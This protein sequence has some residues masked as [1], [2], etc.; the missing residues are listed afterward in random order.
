M[1]GLIYVVGIGPGDFDY[2]CNKAISALGNSDIIVGYKTYIELVKPHFENK[3]FLSSA[4]KKEVDRCLEVLKLAEQGKTVSLISSGDP[5]IYGMAGIMIEIVAAHNSD[6]QVEV[7]PGISASASAASL[8]G[9]PLMNDFAVISLSNLLTPWET[10]EKRLHALAQ[11]DFVISVYN[12]KSKT[13][14]DP[15]YNAIEI[16]LKYK[17]PK[18][19]VGIVRNA[20][21]ENQEIEITDLA[22]LKDAEVNMFTTLIIGN[23]NTDIVNG[24]MV[25][26]RGY[27]L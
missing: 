19:P 5:G 8:L 16:L 24:K 26:I 27:K 10:I 3:N 11:A 1:K 13:R 25:A 14:T 7:I 17:D 9:A 4:M 23:S 2:A 15:F 21:R 6:V 12:P 18:T 20:M 22:N